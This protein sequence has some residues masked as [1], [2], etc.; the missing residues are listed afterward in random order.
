MFVALEVLSLPLYLLCGLARRRRLLVAGGG[1]Q[2]LPARRVLL[3]VLPVR[4]RAAL[5][6]RRLAS[7]VAASPTAVSTTAA[8]D[9]AAA[10]RHRAA[11]ASACCSRSARCRST[12]WT[13]GRLPGRPDAGHRLHGRLHQGRRVRRAAAG[14][15]RRRSA[16]L[17]WDWQP[18]HLGRRDPDDGRRLGARADPDRRQAAA[19]LL[20]DRARRLHPGR[21]AGASTQAGVVE[22][23]V[24]PASPT[25][26]RRSARSPWSRWSATRPARRP[27]C[28]SGPGSAASAR[29]CSPAVF[30]FFLLAFAGIPLTSGFTGKF[31]VFARGDRRRRRLAA[32]RRRCRDAARSRRSST[33]A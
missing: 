32:G 22:H 11:R 28:R 6:L 29:R 8:T 23:A 19:G 30:A 10:R 20:L 12:S 26:S 3:G 25:A 24:L 18:V 5:R 17:R 33:S 1:A 2:V 4:R 15:L 13:P 7:T 21:R 16:A 9:G 31:A 14:V 27:T